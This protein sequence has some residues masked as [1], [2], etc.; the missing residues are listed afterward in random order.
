MIYS[1]MFKAIVTLSFNEIC[2]DA[3]ADFLTRIIRSRT[4]KK[5]YGRQKHL[6]PQGIGYIETTQADKTHIHLLLEIPEIGTT[7]K[8]HEIRQI[9]I[10]LN[11]QLKESCKHFESRFESWM[12]I[13]NDEEAYIKYITKNQGKSIVW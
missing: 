8:L 2:D 7:D 9:L 6:Y 11:R 1:V 4:H 3:R 12:G 13:C 5:L 10:K